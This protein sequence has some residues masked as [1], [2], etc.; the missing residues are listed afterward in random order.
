[1]M[2]FIKRQPAVR[3]IA[4]GFLLVILLGSLL[5]SLP[6]SVREG[7]EL[8]YVDSLY[9]AVSA[10]CV[11][12]LA[13]VD[14]ANTFTPIGQTF[15]ALLIQIGGLGITSVGAGVILIV[16]K[17]M[18]LKSRNLIR[19][20]MNLDSGRGVIRFLKSVFY[21]TLVIEAVG[22]VLNFF[23]FIKD[24]PF[25]RAVGL[26]VFHSI[27]AFNNAGFD[28]LGNFESLSRYYGNVYFNIVTC[29]L[30]FFGGIGFLVIKEVIAKRF[31]WKKLSMHSKVV[32][33]M[34]AILITVGT[35]LFKLTEDVS[36]LGA[37]FASVSART[38]GFA[39]VSLGDFS[40]AG[41]L[42]MIALMF[43]GASPGSTGGGIK[44]S[45][46]F[47]LAQGIRSS[48]TSKSERAFKYTIPKDA[49]KKAAVIVLFALSVVFISTVAVC[50]LE[51]ELALSDILF[52]MASAMGTVGLSTGITPTL[53]AGSKIITM[54]VMYIGRLGAWTIV[55]L[56]SFSREERISYP[57]GNIAIG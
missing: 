22:A 56:W 8:K 35:L 4:V 7:V 18:D 57:E 29:A 53:S 10:V 41:L 11:T 17:K 14:V 46:F 6:C 55:T 49:F 33:T 23:V 26:S 2:D 28:L 40:S 43:I 32:L 24:F 27:S 20:S 52:E 39:T 47:V 15:L 36:W 37:F 16:G 50:A 45:T 42:I 13:T 12:G 1:M 21:T 54:L 48:A 30:I 31:R 44:T 19:E 34:S 38:A 51:P 9:T 25:W 3:I 5:L